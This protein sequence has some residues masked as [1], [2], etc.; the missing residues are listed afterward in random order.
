[1]SV[2]VILIWVLG[3]IAGYYKIME[4]DPIN[5][6]YVLIFGICLFIIGMLCTSIFFACSELR[7]IKQSECE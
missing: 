3:A 6:W 7:A 5:G 1:M 2:G 4:S